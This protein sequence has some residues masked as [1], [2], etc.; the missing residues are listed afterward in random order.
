MVA[1][2]FITLLFQLGINIKLYSLLHNWVADF[3]DY[4]LICGTICCKV[5]ILISFMIPVCLG[6][7]TILGG[8]RKE[9][10]TSEP[11]IFFRST[12]SSLRM[13]SITRTAGKGIIL[14]NEYPWSDSN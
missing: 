9:T 10:A 14:N 1:Y 4:Y 11:P 2:T 7:L 3:L 13:L 5:L 8:A 12:S 6:L